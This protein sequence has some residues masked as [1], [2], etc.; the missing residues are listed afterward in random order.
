MI[1]KKKKPI[2][3]VKS[4]TKTQKIETLE[5][6]EQVR[7]RPGNFF[8]SIDYT[9]Y[10]LADNSTD[11]HLEGFGNV[12]NIELKPDGETTVEDHGRGLPVTPSEKYPD[13]SEAEVAFSSIRSGGKFGTDGAKSSGLNG[14]GSAGINFLSEYFDVT[15]KRD[16]KKYHMRFEKGKCVEKL[17]EIGKVDKNDTGTIIVAKPDQSIWKNLD[18]FDI[19]AIKRRLKQKCYLNTGLTINFKVEY[20]EYDF[21]ESYHFEEGINQYVKDILG[22]EE[23]I[24]EIYN[25]NKSVPIDEDGNTI[26]M[27]IAFCFTEGEGGDNIIGFTNNVSNTDRRSS[28]IDGFKAGLASSIK[29]AIEDSDLN[30]Q[31]FNITNED[32]REGIVSIVSIKL[33]NPFY[34]AQN[35]DRI[36]MP[37]ARS[38][39]SN[40]IEEYLDDI[41]DK[42]PT[43]KD[44]ILR[45]VIEAARIRETARKSKETAKKVKSVGAGKVEGLTK[46]TSKDPTKSEVFLVEGDSAGG[47]AKQARDHETMAILPVFGKINNTY[48]IDIDKLLKSPKIMEA[49]KAFGCGID[50]EFDIEK[51]RYHKI[52]LLTDADV[53]GLHIRCLW[54]TFFFKHMR[55]IIEEGYLYIALPPLFVITKNP[56]TK[57]EQKIFAYSPEEK[58]EIISKLTCKYEVSREKGLGEMD[59]EDL[60]DSTMSKDS[61]K[62]KRVTIEDVE[63]C[64]EILNVCMN[65]RETTARKSFILN[66][67]L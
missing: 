14:I 19:P 43:Q 2:Q 8:S 44:I 62:L 42:N 1:K 34:D 10:E 51:L 47:S 7:L 40:A 6:V 57:K 30:K 3:K 13:K 9:V 26:D 32:T 25:L 66:R 56:R 15:I 22:D 41:F 11:E 60:R 39:V 35:K 53:D 12:I 36:I 28:Q 64:M 45:R 50:E 58:D 27:D 5:E 17:T 46:C 49:V 33:Y 23:P 38:T 54:M 16:G 48:N 21:D 63:A 61:R 31:K 4:T 55:K 52:I 67:G 37:I 65:D 29:N 18:D 24:T 59:W 20:G